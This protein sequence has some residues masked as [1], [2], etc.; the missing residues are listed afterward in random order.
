[1]DEMAYQL[2]MDPIQ[3]RLKNYAEI[4]PD[5]FGEELEAGPYRAAERIAAVALVVEAPA[6]PG[7]SA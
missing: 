7:V 3:I 1:M 2:K 4:D 6:G 5:V